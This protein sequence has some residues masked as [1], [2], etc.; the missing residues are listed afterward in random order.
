MGIEL[1]ARYEEGTRFGRSGKPFEG[2]LAA[3]QES[4]SAQEGRLTREAVLSI[5]TS[6]KEEDERTQEW[7][8]GYDP[9]MDPGF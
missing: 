4:A 7:W 1:F 8:E 3:Q 6:I 5:R 9:G 2:P